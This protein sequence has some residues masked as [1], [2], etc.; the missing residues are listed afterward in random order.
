MAVM[1]TDARLREQHPLCLS[2]P[3]WGKMRLLCSEP[4]EDV[5]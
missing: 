4:L 2:F 3:I 5:T 1:R